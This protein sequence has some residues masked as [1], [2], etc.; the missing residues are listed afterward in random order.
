[1]NPIFKNILAI[2][3]GLVLGSAVNMGIIILGGAII[4]PPPG[5]DVSDMESIKSNMHLYEAKHFI[6]PFL[7][8]AIGTLVG[9]AIAGLIAANHKMKFS[10]GIGGFFLVGGI[11]VNYMLPGPFWFAATDIIFA[12]IPMA[13]IGGTV[14]I[15]IVNK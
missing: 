2:P 15:R 7:A 9:A 11:M 3:A 10:L 12:Y 6:S 5:V 4:A 1:M 13:W 8:H 14:A